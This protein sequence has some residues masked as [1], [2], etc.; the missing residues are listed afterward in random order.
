LPS[1][2]PS[3][4]DFFR[5]RGIFIVD[6]TGNVCSMEHNPEKTLRRLKAR[7]GKQ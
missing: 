4:T 5:R 7:E 3:I 1:P 6:N 2:I